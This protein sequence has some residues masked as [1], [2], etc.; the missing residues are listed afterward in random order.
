T[1][2]KDAGTRGREWCRKMLSK[3][4]EEPPALEASIREALRDFV[5]RR[6]R[7]ITT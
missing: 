4:E 6:E 5:E 3:Y 7:E 2:S 1:G